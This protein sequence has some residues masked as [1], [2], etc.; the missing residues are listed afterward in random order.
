MRKYYS[1]IDDMYNAQLACSTI[2]FSSQCRTVYCCGK[3]VVCCE[4]TDIIDG[5]IIEK[6]ILCPKCAEQQ[7]LTLKKQQR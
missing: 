3:L 2:S 7:T 4:I 5:C 6:M 1:N